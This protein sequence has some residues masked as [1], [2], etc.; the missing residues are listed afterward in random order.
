MPNALKSKGLDDVAREDGKPLCNLRRLLSSA[1]EDVVGVEDVSVVLE[2]CVTVWRSWK[3]LNDL[4]DVNGEDNKLMHTSTRV[5]LDRLSGG[6]VCVS[7]VIES[8]LV[9]PSEQR[10]R[11][12]PLN[13]RPSSKLSPPTPPPSSCC[14]SEEFGEELLVVGENHCETLEVTRFNID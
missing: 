14:G 5:V 4:E 8:G 7:A 12:W 3:N 2:V 10:R 13:S 11:W 1:A 6:C 9:M